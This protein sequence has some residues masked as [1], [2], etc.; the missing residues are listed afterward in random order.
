ME[1]S[2]RPIKGI[3]YRIVLGGAIGNLLKIEFMMVEHKPR[4]KQA[5]IRRAQWKLQ[6]LTQPEWSSVA[7]LYGKIKAMAINRP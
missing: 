6:S 7:N 4:K 2:A 1:R 5:T 3:G